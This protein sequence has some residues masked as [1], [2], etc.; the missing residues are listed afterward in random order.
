MD[1]LFLLPIAVN[2]AFPNASSTYTNKVLEKTREAVFNQHMDPTKM[3]YD[4]GFE[5]TI[6]LL[7]SIATEAARS[8]TP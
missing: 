3:I 5:K 1:P 2:R 6:N 4:F 7:I 8:V